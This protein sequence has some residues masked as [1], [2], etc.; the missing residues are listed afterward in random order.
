MTGTAS[1]DIEIGGIR[2]IDMVQNLGTVASG[3]FKQEVIMIVQKAIGMNDSP[4]SLLGR[5]EIRKELFAVEI[6]PK[7]GFAFI[8]P[9]GYMIKSSGI[10]NPQGPGHLQF[11]LI[12][13]L[14]LCPIPSNL[15]IVE[16]C[17]LASTGV[18]K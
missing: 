8:S 15:S 13:F 18:K 10:L 14:P 17:P 4:I 2:S 7:D 11:L 9:G 16:T 3:G 12:P 5:L 1:F 6:A